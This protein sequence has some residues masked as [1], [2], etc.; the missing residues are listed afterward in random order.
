MFSHQFHWPKV[1][2]A[3][4]A[5]ALVS[6][7]VVKA[8]GADTAP[9]SDA[10]PIAVKVLIDENKVLNET[11][12]L[13]HG[14]NFVSLWNNVGNSPETTKALAQ[15]NLKLLRFPGGCPAEWYDWQL[16]KPPGYTNWTHEQAWDLA[17][18]TGMQMVYQTNIAGDAL[19]TDKKTGEQWRFNSSGEHQAGWLKAAAEKQIKVAFWE[20][21]NEP[22]MDAPAQAKKG[23]DAIMRWYNAK[24][25]EQVRAIQKVDPK[26]RTMAG[27]LTNMYQWWA[28]RNLEKLLVAHG[29]KKGTGLIDAISLHWYLGG[30]KGGWAKT[31]AYPQQWYK[32]MTYIN[33]AIQ[34]YDTR[35][36]P[37]Y[38]TEWN[39]GGGMDNVSATRL[40]CALGNAD[41]VGMFLKTGIKGHTHFCLHGAF[42]NW[43]ML[44]MKGA[45]KEG[46]E[47]APSYFSLALAARLWGKVV[48]AKGDVDEA[49]V[50]S[51]YAAQDAS[52]T[53]NVMLINK[54]E[55]PAHV[56]L[57][58]ANLKTAGKDA[59][60]YRLESASGE[61]SDTGVIYNGVT[62]PQPQKDDLP[63]PAKL[64]L[65]ADTAVDLKPYSMV[66]VAIA[67]AAPIT[68]K[69][70]RRIVPETEITRL[71]I[72]K[73]KGAGPVTRPAITPVGVMSAPKALSVESDLAAWKDIA[74]M[75]LPFQKKDESS[76]KLAWREDG[77]LGL[78]SAK[79]ASVKSD[80]EKP[81]NAECFELFIEK[82]AAGS[83]D[84]VKS[85]QY[86]F[87]PNPA[88]GAGKGFV[89]IAYGPTAADKQIQCQWKPTDGG[90][91][92][93][94][95]IPAECL[96]PAKLAP[97]TKL[98]LTFALDIA[99][100][101]VEQFFC[102][103][104]AN[105]NYANPNAWGL[106]VLNK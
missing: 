105:S 65:T 96:A 72:G 23:S 102:N 86:M 46:S 41:V 13:Y 16:L 6:A 44:Y 89:D 97:D 5:A 76:V 32:G 8:R 30:E 15:S 40:D 77:L 26:A 57:A 59:L 39:F 7:A 92:L 64:K 19:H 11:D 73:V 84:T 90:Y 1:L 51:V 36:L 93:A 50:L 17:K 22:E 49:Q 88:G 14:T 37:V 69:Y 101:P 53:M 28:E 27:A 79:T 20:I 104:G 67:N 52:N 33:G 21:G 99:G 71:G 38:I 98:G 56:A 35:D 91:M 12:E 31:R 106:V 25:E 47:A 63:A 45:G 24:F 48:E 78:V 4:C 70:E 66:V 81:Y 34:T 85:T 95:F 103:K 94:F 80:R 100:K 82:D 2:P 61:V 10:A 29:N 43:G 62:N 83:V 58:F 54:S 42:K 3:V 68:A 55:K 75:P 18:A 60:V 9:Q 74:S 87:S